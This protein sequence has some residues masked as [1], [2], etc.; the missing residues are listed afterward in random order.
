MSP[1]IPL[2]TKIL[3][4]CALNLALFCGAGLG[5]AWLQLQYGTESILL[6]PASDKML[7]I[8]ASLPREL[9]SRPPE[10]WQTVFD[11]LERQYHA[12]AYLTSP[13]G[14]RFAGRAE[15]L[16]SEVRSRFQHDRPRGAPP[17]A[18]GAERKKGPPKKGAKKEAGAPPPV[19]L[20]LTHDPTRYWIG[21]RVPVPS[22]DGTQPGMLVLEADSMFNPALFL[23]LRLLSGVAL[24]GITLTLLCWFW[25]VH[26]LTSAVHQMAAATERI[27]EGQFDV[28]LKTSR[29]DELGHLARQI[30]RMAGRLSHLVTGQKRFLGDIAHELCAPVARMEMSL[31]IL[32]QRLRESEQESLTDLREEVEQIAALVN[33][34]LQ[35]SKAAI[36]PEAVVLEP[37]GV[38]AT[39]TRVIGR[40][41]AEAP[42]VTVDVPS[43][44]H[45]MANEACFARS[46]SNLVR[47]AMRYAGHAGP[48]EIAAREEAND[49]VITVADSGP[50]VREDALDKLFEPFYRPEESRSRESGGAGLGLAIVKAGIETCRGS[51]TCKNRSPNGLEVTIR[52]PALT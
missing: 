11:N 18:M 15:V 45:V 34:L 40:E 48:I 52:L 36:R 32:E 37:V 28:A 46:L 9:A 26:G 22:E 41:G 39:V 42:A 4:L 21:A 13:E 31:G 2:S 19:F 8:S 6:G 38:A 24:A 17:P 44:L 20:V 23:D 14:T 50:G 3:L 12:R 35:F 1:R 5:Y 33:E 27:A 49:V 47:N 30:N 10:S 29:S 7:A 16:P 43:D 25:F 51:V